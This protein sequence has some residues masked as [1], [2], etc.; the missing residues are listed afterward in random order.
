METVCKVKQFNNLQLVTDYPIPSDLLGIYVLSSSVNSEKII[1]I[2]Q[3]E[4]KCVI[5]PHWRINDNIENYI[6]IPMLS[7]K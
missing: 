5:V 3:I 4:R 6:C 2:D 7:H 1:S